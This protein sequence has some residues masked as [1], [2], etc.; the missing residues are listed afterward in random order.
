MLAH[1]KIDGSVVKIYNITIVR[2]LIQDKLGKIRLFKE[3]FLLA[4]NNIDV[5]LGML[6]LFLT[7][8]DIKF[9]M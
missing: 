6:F 8:V 7:N 1:K 5:V 4:Y 9:N 3:T 2:F